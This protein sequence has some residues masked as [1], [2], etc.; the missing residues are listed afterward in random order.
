MFR[1]IN[2]T[3]TQQE[4]WENINLANRSMCL[5]SRFIIGLICTRTAHHRTET[6]RINNVSTKQ[7]ITNVFIYSGQGST[8][9]MWNFYKSIAS[10]N[11][12][13]YIINSLQ[14]DFPI[15]ENGTQKLSLVKN[16]ITQG[17]AEPSVI[18]NFV[19]KDQGYS[20]VDWLPNIPIGLCAGQRTCLIG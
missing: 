13:N 12:D 17:G 7:Q 14:P 1:V 16:K 3:I 11:W 8:L 10:N 19:R 2:V 18:I 6:Q 15:K 9:R 20:Y 5:H 4:M